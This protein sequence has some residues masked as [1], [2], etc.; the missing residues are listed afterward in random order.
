MSYLTGK[1]SSIETL[2]GLAIVLMVAGHVVGGDT[3]GMK[4]PENHAFRYI[5]DSLVYLRMPLFTVISGFVY[6]IRPLSPGGYPQ[7]VKG[8]LRRLVYPLIFVSTIY[9]ILQ[10]FVPS[11]NSKVEIENI[12]KIYFISYLH[13]WYLH[14]LLLVFATIMLMEYFNLMKTF[15][16]WLICLVV[17]LIAHFTV[18]SL[19]ETHQVP[20]ILGSRKY[21]F[22]LTFFILGVGLNRFKDVFSNKQIF[23]V[24]LAAFVCGILIQ[25][26][27]ILKVITYYYR[28]ASLL[29]MLVGLAGITSVFYLRKSNRFL[30]EM[31]NFSYSIYLFHVLC[32][33]GNRILLNKLHINNI[34]VVFILGLLSGIFI[35][36]F[37]EIIFSKNPLTRK[38]LLGKKA[39]MKLETKNAN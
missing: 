4:L 34:A 33:A 30:A 29:G 35:P 11:V 15:R 6:A 38:F 24:V 3:A 16:G 10:T 21:L 37:L 26:L 12:W 31:G 7:F 19:L 39:R 14:S 20:N 36:V 17:T 25:Q 8:K 2:R 9:F 5:N 1:D 27:S 32:A 22:L 18:L 28:P 23:S 13:L